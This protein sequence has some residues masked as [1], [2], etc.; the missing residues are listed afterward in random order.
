[1]ESKRAVEE[2]KSYYLASDEYRSTNNPFGD[3]GS[4]LTDTVGC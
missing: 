3:V 1:M 2:V 4:S